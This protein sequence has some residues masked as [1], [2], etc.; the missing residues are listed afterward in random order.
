MKITTANERAI[1][2]ASPIWKVFRKY[3]LASR[4]MTCEFC[5]KQYKDASKLNVHHMYDTNYDNLDQKRFMLVCHT[6]HEFIHAKCNSPL[7]KD[8]HL[9]HRKD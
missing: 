5:G 8:R 6:C 3:I 2:R 7:L 9:A 4:H 1:F